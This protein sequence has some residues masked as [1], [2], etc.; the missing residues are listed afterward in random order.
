MFQSRF[1][2][3][4]SRKTWH[5]VAIT[6]PR[7][8]TMFA[9][10]CQEDQDCRNILNRPCRLNAIRPPTQC[11]CHFVGILET[12]R[13]RMGLRRWNFHCPLPFFI[14]ISPTSKAALV[15]L[16]QPGQL[17]TTSWAKTS[18]SIQKWLPQTSQAYLPL[19]LVPLIST[20]ILD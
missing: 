20:S 19:S 5:M 15:S 10:P 13:I 9:L 3:M 2:C 14:S 4:H 1:T 17:C 18:Q 6:W 8:T 11:I 7:A 16:W 12:P